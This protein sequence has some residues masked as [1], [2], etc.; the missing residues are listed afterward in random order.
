MVDQH[1]ARDFARGAGAREVGLAFVAIVTLEFHGF[2]DQAWI[3]HAIPH[4]RGSVAK[5]NKLRRAWNAPR[6]TYAARDIMA[7]TEGACRHPR[8][9]FSTCSARWS[10]GGAASRAGQRPSSSLS[11]IRS[12]GSPSPMR[13]AASISRRW[14]RFAVA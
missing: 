3:R 13:G 1:H 4:T 5:Y 9:F 2:R 10:M 14:R 11:A 8:L 7:A 12:I 6:H